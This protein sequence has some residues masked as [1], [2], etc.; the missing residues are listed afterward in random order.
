LG[1]N[2]AEVSDV[3][4]RVPNRDK[5]IIDVRKVREY[6]LS[7]TH[8]VGRFK[9]KYFSGLG[10]DADVWTTLEAHLRESLESEK[11]EAIEGEFGATFVVR[12]VVTSPSGTISRL[13]TVWIVLNGEENPRFVTA[14]PES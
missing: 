4:M 13:T 9:A 7:S 3:A 2:N 10:Y 5:A 14:Y 11:V 12:S 6:L 1:D 8:P